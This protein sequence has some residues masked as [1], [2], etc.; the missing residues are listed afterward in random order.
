MVQRVTSDL[1]VNS[2]GARDRST[3]MSFV[4]RE[5][6]KSIRCERLGSRGVR[7]AQLNRY[8]HARRARAQGVGGPWQSSRSCRT[9]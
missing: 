6:A 5:R 8:G 2:D 4:R 7:S 9:R 1:N 3:S